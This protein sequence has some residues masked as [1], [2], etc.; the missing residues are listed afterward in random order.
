MFGMSVSEGRCVHN[1]CTVYK[2]SDWALIA[3]WEQLQYWT[4]FS[5]EK[6][7]RIFVKLTVII[8]NIGN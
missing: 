5:R 2:G 7:T 6:K 4:Y 8:L 3:G 1:V